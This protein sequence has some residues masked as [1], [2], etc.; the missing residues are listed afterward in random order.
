MY[1]RTRRG[2]GQFAV[3]DADFTKQGFK[4]Y[5]VRTVISGWYACYQLFV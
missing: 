2:F 4:S 5:Q 1:V 3:A